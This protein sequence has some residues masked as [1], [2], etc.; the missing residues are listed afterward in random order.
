MESPEAEL[1]SVIVKTVADTMAQPPE[2][3][4][5]RAAYKTIV[6]AINV[7][8]PPI[9]S[10][11]EGFPGRE[12]FYRPCGYTSRAFRGIHNDKILTILSSCSS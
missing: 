5:V 6:R 2:I 3:L 8:I 4:A 9:L 7:Y 10:H 12:G 11:F 1:V